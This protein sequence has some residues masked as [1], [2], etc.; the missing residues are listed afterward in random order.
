MS[1]TL[2]APAKVNL[3]L[4]IFPPDETG[5]H[6]LDTLFC[7][8]NLTDEISI[9]LTGG[10]LDLEVSGA[11]LGAT[12]HNLAYRAAREFFAALGIAPRA[13]IRLHKK[14]PAGAGLGGGSS[15]AASVLIGLNQLHD[16]VLPTDDLLALGARLGSD[17]AF[18]LCGAPLAHATG[19]GEKLRTLPSLPSLPVLIAIPTFAIATVDAYRWLDEAAA[20]SREA[21]GTITPDSWRIVAQHARN[22]FEPV[23]LQKHP[24]L[25]DVKR[26]I[27]GSGALV[28]LLS[29]SGS[30]LFGV[31]THSDA[32]GRAATALRRM[33]P[34]LSI[35]ETSTRA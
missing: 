2:A 12:E 16:G 14:I 10:A 29:G 20:Y 4:N 31:Y 3:W 21:F 25:A 6:P 19:R 7:A 5:Y 8:L 34:R 35:V 17:V 32:C 28:T 11:E 18:F 26:A 15:D 33:W 9:D 23:V 27:A 24:M 13:T 22:A 1:L 30:T